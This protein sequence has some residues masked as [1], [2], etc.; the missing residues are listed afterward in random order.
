[1]FFSSGFTSWSSDRD[2]EHVFALLETFYGAFDKIALARDVFKVETIGDCYLAITGCPSPQDDHAIRMAKFARHCMYTVRDLTDVLAES[3]G[4]DTRAL[5]FRVGL[6]SGSVT[7]GVL[8]GD[9]TRFQLFGDTVNTA[10]RIESH[11]VKGRIHVSQATFDAICKEVGRGKSSG[12]MIPRRDK[13]RAKGKGE[14]QTYFMSGK[15]MRAAGKTNSTTSSRSY[16]SQGINSKDCNDLTE[17]DF[18][19]TIMEFT[20]YEDEIPA[21]AAAFR[22]DV[23]ERDDSNGEHSEF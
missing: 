20:D 10:A 23:T 22:Q 12:W 2:P 21:V 6:H 8:R 3:L 1:M 5:S 14:L 18:T 16:S 11:G 17:S 9:R 19:D 13:V 4:D 7:A 15:F